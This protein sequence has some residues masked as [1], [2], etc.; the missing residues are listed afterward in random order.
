[1]TRYENHCCSC[2]T[3]LYPCA[4]ESC[5]LRH[6]KIYECDN[7]HSEVDEGELFQFEGQE[8][9]IDCIC[10]QLEKVE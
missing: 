8:L 3:D 2:A 5:K 6:V 7:C 1:M 10:K 9:C 4:G